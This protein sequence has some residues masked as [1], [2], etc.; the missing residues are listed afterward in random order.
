MTEKG[1]GP[2]MRFLPLV[3]WFKE[4]I[5][6]DAPFRL[7]FVP[8][9][10]FF[11]R[12]P[13][14]QHSKFRAFFDQVFTPEIFA[15][16]AAGEVKI[17]KHQ[18]WNEDPEERIEALLDKNR[19]HPRDEDEDRAAGRKLVKVAAEKEGGLPGPTTP[20]QVVLPPVSGYARPDKDKLVW[21][22]GVGQDHQA[23]MTAWSFW[24]DTLQQYVDEDGKLKGAG[25]LPGTDSKKGCNDAKPLLMEIRDRSRGDPVR[26][27]A[28]LDI[29]KAMMVTDKWPAV[30]SGSERLVQMT[31]EMRCN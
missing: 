19:K 29:I 5:L 8:D 7:R 27:K 25:W 14:F 30:V 9:A 26:E 1:P 16:H 21:P 22:K 28:M 4:I 11:S 20:P 12:H 23:F 2:V 6:Q 18:A 24:R 10:A 3:R 17:R 31:S 15:Q 13:L